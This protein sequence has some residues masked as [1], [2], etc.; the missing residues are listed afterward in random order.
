MIYQ[1]LNI[2]TEDNDIREDLHRCYYLSKPV[3]RA[4][5]SDLI[6]T[7]NKFNHNMVYMLE[8]HEKHFNRLDSNMIINQTKWV[9]ENYNLF[10][11]E[12]Y[13]N[14]QVLNVTLPCYAIDVNFVN[15]ETFTKDLTK[16]LVGCNIIEGSGANYTTPNPID[17]DESD[18]KWLDYDIDRFY[19]LVNTIPD[20]KAQDFI[21]LILTMIKQNRSRY[22]D[23]VN[24]VR[25]MSVKKPL[26]AKEDLDPLK[27]YTIFSNLHGIGS[28]FCNP[29]EFLSIIDTDGVLKGFLED[30]KSWDID[31]II[32]ECKPLFNSLDEK[33]EHYFNKINNLT[34]IEKYKL[35][36]TIKKDIEI[37]SDYDETLQTHPL[38]DSIKHWSV[39]PDECMKNIESIIYNLGKYKGKK[40]DENVIN[41]Y[42]A[43]L[44]RLLEVLE[45]YKL[46]YDN[47][48]WEHVGCKND[49]LSDDPI[50]KPNEM[51]FGKI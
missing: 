32:S 29:K 9:Y 36:S 23:I 31:K 49:M 51:K 24:I 1:K 30:P 2:R 18:L 13:F 26:V 41:V 19:E 35:V 6:K 8:Q 7:L 3:I 38:L 42:I 37:K 17:V 22:S 45:Y 50:T 4:L 16:T 10:P 11:N 21:F 48:I 27:N 5:G 44:R 34:I 15:V 20:K 28:V 46:H 12:K 43:S 25:K 39:I 33:I 40:L 14:R 47:Q